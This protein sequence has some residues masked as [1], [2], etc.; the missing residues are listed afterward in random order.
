MFLLEDSC[1]DSFVV[2]LLGPKHKKN[3]KFHDI[4]SFHIL[5]KRTGCLVYSCVFCV[6]L[7]RFTDSE[8]GSC[9]TSDP[10]F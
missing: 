5:L 10:Q 4:P 7:G 3:L 1:E 8:D 9:K 2:Y 6:V